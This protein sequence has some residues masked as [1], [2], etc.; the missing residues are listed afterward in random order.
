MDEQM[1]KEF[2]EVINGLLPD[3]DIKI[4]SAADL[5]GNPNPAIRELCEAAELVIRL[6]REERA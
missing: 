5:D 1:L 4:R 2:N 6:T 3:R